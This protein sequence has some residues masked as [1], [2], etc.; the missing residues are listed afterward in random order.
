MTNS[1]LVNNQP[2]N[3]GFDS[4]NTEL[5]ILSAALISIFFGLY[6][7]WWILRIEI[8]NKDEELVKLRDD[9]LIQK[10]KEM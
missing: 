1:S 2:I 5:F 4:A 7:A 3:L 6:N 9:R 10:F 8:V